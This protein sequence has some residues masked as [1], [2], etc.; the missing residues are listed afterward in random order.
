MSIPEKYGEGVTE[1][2][3]LHHS[4][5]LSLTWQYLCLPFDAGLGAGDFTQSER[6]LI[7]KKLDVLG[8]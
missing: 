2:N 4:Q 3:E 1:L 5:P 6:Q 8:N 7:A